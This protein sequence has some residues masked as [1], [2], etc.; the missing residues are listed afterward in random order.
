MNP[1]YVLAATRCR[2]DMGHDLVQCQGRGIDHLG[3][4][5][6]MGDHRRGY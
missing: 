2:R 3:L 6:G 1:G 5:A 4:R